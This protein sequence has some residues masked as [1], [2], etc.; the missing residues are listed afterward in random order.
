[1][2]VIIIV[3]DKTVSDPKNIFPSSICPNREETCKIMN[4]PK[5]TIP[6]APIIDECKINRLVVSINAQNRAE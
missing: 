2:V 5:K 3:E 1:M 6:N 4:M